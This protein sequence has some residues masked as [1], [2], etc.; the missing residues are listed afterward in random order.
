MPKGALTRATGT[1]RAL[2]GYAAARELCGEAGLWVDPEK[3]VILPRDM[4]KIAKANHLDFATVLDHR[5][6]VQGPRY[7]YRK[8]VTHD[9]CRDLPGAVSAGDRCHVWA[10]IDPLLE[11]GDL[12]P[13][14]R[15]PLKHLKEVELPKAREFRNVLEASGAPAAVGPVDPARG[16]HDEYQRYVDRATPAERCSAWRVAH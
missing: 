10:T 16:G 14:C 6:A 12:L 3:L 7:K 11:R 2:Q 8:E 5:L 9:G 15:R 1:T 4:S 13:F